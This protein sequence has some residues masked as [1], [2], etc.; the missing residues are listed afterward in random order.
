MIIKPKSEDTYSNDGGKSM[1]VFID[2][3]KIGDLVEFPKEFGRSWHVILCGRL[4]FSN[5]QFATEEGAT[6]YMKLCAY[7]ENHDLKM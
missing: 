6:K 1:T 3:Q 2:G 7:A 5:A 4:G